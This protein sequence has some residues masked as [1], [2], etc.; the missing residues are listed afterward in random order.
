MSIEWEHIAKESG[1]SE[2]ELRL[3]LT[4]LLFQ[5]EHLTL[6]QAARVAGLHQA[7][8]QMELAKRK[9]PIHYGTEEFLEDMKTLKKLF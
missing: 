2:D 5:E 7:Q 3:K 8:F 9:I 6:A 4:L 1:L